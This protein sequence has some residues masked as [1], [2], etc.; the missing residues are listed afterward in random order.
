MDQLNRE[1][2]EAQLQAALDEIS[3]LPRHP[4]GFQGPVEP[5]DLIFVARFR[6]PT[7]GRTYVAEP[8]ELEPGKGETPQPDLFLRDYATVGQHRGTPLVDL[9]EKFVPIVVG[10]KGR[11]LTDIINILIGGKR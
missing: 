3:K 7:T 11:R 1:A 9:L 10:G 8:A 4:R 2:L 5:L 6:D